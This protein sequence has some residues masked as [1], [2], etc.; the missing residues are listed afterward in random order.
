M[1][2]CV[3]SWWQRLPAAI[4]WPRP[5]I[6]DAQGNHPGRNA[7][8]SESESMRLGDLQE[9]TPVADAA[10]RVLAV[11][12]EAVRDCLDRALKT[13][14]DRRKSIHALRVATRRAAA[15]IEVFGGCLPRRVFKEARTS[16]RTLRRAVGAARDWDVLL[17]QLTKRLKAAADSERPAIDMLHGYALA[18]RIPAQRRLEAA[19]PDHP[20][21]FDRLMAKCVAAVR[22][23]IGVPATFGSHVRPILAQ[24][25][26]R[27]DE[28]A[29]GGD[30]DW[31]R[32]HEVRIAGKR[33]RYTL[34]LVQD[35]FGG[36]LLTQLCPSLEQLQEILGQVNDSFNAVSLL[37]QIIEGIAGCVPDA[38]DRYRHLLEQHAAEHEELM[39]QGRDA[40][41]N[42]LAAWNG[43]EMQ[44]AL[45]TLCP[46]SGHRIARKSSVAAPE[47]IDPTAPIRRT[48]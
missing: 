19:C 1:Q 23:R 16:M 39:R 14:K 8:V 30:G 29:S 33:L 11:R 20:F 3:R 47:P 26:G 10:R 21:G 12:L 28:H 27:L 24:R 44:D 43:T 18:H 6:R 41:R 35:S 22:D 7:T 13:P 32:L 36:P 48:A 37:R 2:P 42:W 34:E 9:S 4:A 15:A 31:A 17:Q 25:V 45:R 46:D 38:N 40:Y 5:G